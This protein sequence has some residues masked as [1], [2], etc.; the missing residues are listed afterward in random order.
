M[1][2]ENVINYAF[3]SPQINNRHFY[4]WNLDYIIIHQSFIPYLYLL[5]F[6]YITRESKVSLSVIFISFARTNCCLSR[7][8]SIFLSF[9]KDSRKTPSEKTKVIRLAHW[10]CISSIYSYHYCCCRCTRGLLT[11]PN[12]A[13]YHLEMTS[14]TTMGPSRSATRVCKHKAVGSA[15]PLCNACRQLH[16]GHVPWSRRRLLMQQLDPLECS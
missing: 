7:H 10:R 6:I 9:Y 2:V 1:D 11:R 4:L 8:S 14:M 5:P 12:A 16:A 15:S 3:S 13:I